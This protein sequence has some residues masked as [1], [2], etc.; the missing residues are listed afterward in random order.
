LREKNE[1]GS[2]LL[3]VVRLLVYAGWTV[4]LLPVQIVAV[5]LRL[6][7]R[8]TLPVLYHRG[9]LR[10][11]GFKV[12]VRGRCSLERPTLFISNHSSYLDIGV[13]GSLI[14]GS[15]VAKA[16]VGS[17]PLFGF[18]AKLQETVFVNRAARRSADSQRNELA[19]RM[20]AGD[21]LI[22]FPEGTS[23]DGN[24][25]LPFK[26]ALFAAAAM[27]VHGRPV[28]VQ[29]VSVVATALDGIPLGWSWRDVYAWYGDMA[30][31]PHLWRLVTLGDLTLVV[32]FHPA[33]TIAAF[34]SRKELAGYCQDR[35]AAGVERAVTGRWDEGPDPADSAT[36]DE[37]DERDADGVAVAA[38]GTA[39]AGAAGIGA[40]GTPL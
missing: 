3:G 10:I 37:G 5:A 24:R 12:V 1:M 32:E 11:L 8:Q 15:F 9:C 38:A 14:P 29:P 4:L 2:P 34:A 21:S 39:G 19:R 6:R 33:V 35:V 7:L 36:G 40:V 30:M 23:S 22:L 27:P 17:W 20:E 28:T 26:T 16:E 25:V 31:A 13:L 18:L